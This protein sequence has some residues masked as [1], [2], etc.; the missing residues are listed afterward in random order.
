[1]VKKTKKHT[2]T[3]TNPLYQKVP[4]CVQ[5]TRFVIATLLN[6]NLWYGGQPP[7]PSPSLPAH[8]PF[9]TCP[10]SPRPTSPHHLHTFTY[11]PLSPPMYLVPPPPLTLVIPEPERQNILCFMT[12]LV[13]FSPSHL[14]ACSPHWI[15]EHC[16][17]YHNTQY[18]PG[19]L[20]CHRVH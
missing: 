5:R 18:S 4:R 15:S 12:S 1:M 8:L 6:A 2:H 13:L 19:D 17:E 7:S 10:F 20:E 16:D 11:H 3:H 14:Y 9:V